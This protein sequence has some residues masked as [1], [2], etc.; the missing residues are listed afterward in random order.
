MSKKP[1]VKDTEKPSIAEFIAI[2]ILD[3]AKHKHSKNHTHDTSD[4]RGHS[5]SGNLVALIVDG[6]VREV[7]HASEELKEILLSNPEMI[8]LE[9]VEGFVRPTIGWTYKD[10]LMSPPEEEK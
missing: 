3:R 2:K 1:K 10:G 6:V 7:V 8:L 9:D 5:H 4:N